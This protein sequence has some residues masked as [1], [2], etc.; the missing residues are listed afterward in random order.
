MSQNQNDLFRSM[1]AEYMLTT[2]DNLERDRMMV[3]NRISFKSP[4]ADDIYSIIVVETRQDFSR[5]V[6]RA[7]REIMKDYLS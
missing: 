5:A 2:S 7:I 6:F 4:T 1:L 3:L